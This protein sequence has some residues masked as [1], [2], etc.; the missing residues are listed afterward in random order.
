MLIAV[1]ELGTCSQSR[2]A[3]ILAETFTIRRHWI[4]CENSPDL[5]S[6]FD[7]YPAFCRF[8]SQVVIRCW[9]L[10]GLWMVLW[11]HVAPFACRSQWS[12]RDYPTIHDHTRQRK[13][14][15][16]MYCQNLKWALVSSMCHAFSRQPCCQNNQ[17]ELKELIELRFVLSW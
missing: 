7:K 4:T 16:R 8:P 1:S 9:R 5:R 14:S 2:A 12:F 11:F 17:F 6:I 10:A 13:L 15:W 3:K